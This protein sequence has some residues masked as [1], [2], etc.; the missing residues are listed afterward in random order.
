MATG[1]A[2]SVVVWAAAQARAALENRGH[3]LPDDVKALAPSVL[4]HRLV[5]SAEARARGIDDESLVAQIVDQVPVPVGVD[6]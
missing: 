5:L 3:A 2:S 1:W 4:A 6:A